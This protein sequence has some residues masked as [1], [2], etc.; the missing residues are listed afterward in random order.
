MVAQTK[1]LVSVIIV[2]YND[3]KYIG[4]SISSVLEQS[5]ADLELILINH[6]SE[7]GSRSIAHGFKDQRIVHLDM[8]QNIGASGGLLLKKGLAL[9]HGDYIRLFGADDV[10]EKNCIEQLMLSLRDQRG[11]IIFSDMSYI[12]G[13]GTVQPGL[14]STTRKNFSFENSSYDL[15]DLYIDG[16]STLPFPSVLL[17]KSVFD[18]LHI[19]DSLVYM[20]DMSLWVQALLRN[21][22]FCYLQAS[23]VRYRI[24]DGQT[25]SMKKFNEIS[26]SC[27]F[28]ALTFFESFL[29]N[30]PRWF[31]SYIIT[32]VNIVVSLDKTENSQAVNCFFVSLYGMMCG[33]QAIKYA[34]YVHL[35]KIID[36]SATLDEINAIYPFSIKDFREIYRSNG[37][38]LRKSDVKKKNNKC[39]WGSKIKDRLSFFVNRPAKTLK[40]HEILCLFILRPSLLIYKKK[41]QL[42]NKQLNA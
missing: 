9:A 26:R 2:Y 18:D 36:D 34:A 16:V 6:A 41:K 7:D 29:C 8:E 13:E 28:E 5:W 10:M 33:S 3:E 12:D 4:E 24:H 11:D 40:L 27:M 31:I 19:D 14:W 21:Y 22:K 25:S 23:T 35:K 42:S 17:R 38:S 39:F 32:K 1:S 37:E 30:P 15:L 20:L